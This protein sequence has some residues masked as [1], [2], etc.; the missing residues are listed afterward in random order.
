MIIT[1]LGSHQ[2]PGFVTPNDIGTTAARLCPLLPL[3]NQ[4]SLRNEFEW[5]RAVLITRVS[6]SDRQSLHWEV[7]EPA[8]LLVITVV[9]TPDLLQIQP[10]PVFYEMFHPCKVHFVILFQ[11]LG[12][13]LADF[14]LRPPV[15]SAASVSFPGTS[16][17]APYSL[18]PAFPPTAPSA[19]NCLGPA[20]SSRPAV[21]ESGP[22]AQ[23]TFPP[24]PSSALPSEPPP[25]R[26][27]P[28]GLTPVTP[29]LVLGV[30]RP[31]VSSAPPADELQNLH[32][33][34]AKSPS[35]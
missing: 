14:D 35:Q 21:P 10:F 17:T 15:V 30:A 13:G 20:F 23:V 32:L 1:R 7:A 4:I 24:P 33:L 25:A 28:S 3:Q 27:Q 6:H 2:N 31:P 12:H 18:P 34:E 29:P 11:E 5:T 8:T 19:L 16:S 9:T 22:P 26:A